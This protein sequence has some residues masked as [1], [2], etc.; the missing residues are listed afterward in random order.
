MQEKE[1]LTWRIAREND[2]EEAWR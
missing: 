1:E 2:V